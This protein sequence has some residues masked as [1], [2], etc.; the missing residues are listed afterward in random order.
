MT[1]T[2]QQIA[3]ELEAKELVRERRR[4]KYPKGFGILIFGGVL[5]YA[6]QFT[7]LRL[8]PGP[9]PSV[10]IGALKHEG[11]TAYSVNFMHDGSIDSADFSIRFPNKLESGRVGVA[12][13]IGKSE[14]EYIRPLVGEFGMHDGK[15]L[16]EPTWKE[17]V[18]DS[19][20]VF[21]IVG[22]TAFVH[23]AR[24]SGHIPV[25]ALFIATTGV[26]TI[27][28]APAMEFIGEYSYNLIGMTAIKKITLIDQGVMK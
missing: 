13:N 8:W 9:R 23:I 12:Q 27:T 1:R 14:E 21:K 26:S 4:W 15:C 28:P 24:L 6:G 11:C 2:I 5:T 7:L 25:G 17:Q 20:A 3:R 10:T 19:A 22:N 18:D 16:L